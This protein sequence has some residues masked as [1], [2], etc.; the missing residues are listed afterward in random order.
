LADQLLCLCSFDV[1]KGI[2]TLSLNHDFA[3][4]RRMAPLNIIIPMQSS[5]TTSL[6]GKNFNGKYDGFEPFP[7]NLPTIHGQYSDT[8]HIDVQDFKTRLM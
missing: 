7:S 8:R 6:P 4:L 5:L 2:N 3:I 1:Q